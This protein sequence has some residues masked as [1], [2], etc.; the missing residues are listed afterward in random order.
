MLYGDEEIIRA[1]VAAQAKMQHTIENKVIIEGLEYTFS[2]RIINERFE[3]TIPDNFDVMPESHA[4][5]KYPSI[6]RPKLIL[7]N[8]G[9]TVDIIFDFD[10]PAD[11]SL[12]G[13][14]IH[15]RM[16]LKRL[17]PAYVFFSHR[18]LSLE[19]NIA[20]AY[21][22]FRSQALDVD[23]Y[24]LWFLFDLPNSGIF[25]GFSCSIEQRNMWEPLVRQMINTIK[26]L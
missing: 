13:R 25:G 23:I 20:I 5:K 1:R 6:N 11:G 16:V 2:S 22:D 7:T 3:I 26:P 17:N 10:I 18:I 24:N 19:S 4:I 21:F 8:P 15:H 9:S 12:E 14:I